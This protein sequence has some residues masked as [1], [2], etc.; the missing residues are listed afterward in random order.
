MREPKKRRRARPKQ[1]AGDVDDAVH[2]VTDASERCRVVEI[3]V[4][5]LAIP[6]DL[7]GDG[8]LMVQQAQIVRLGQQSAGEMRAQVSRCPDDEDLQP[9]ARYLVFPGN[10]QS[11]LIT[12]SG[13]LGFSATQIRR[14]WY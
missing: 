9:I 12:H 7:E 3:A 8:A 1:H 5:D 2:A 14:P 10:G 13:H 6:P 11:S 4:D